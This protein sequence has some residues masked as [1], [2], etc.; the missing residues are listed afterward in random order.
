MRKET[1]T[2]IGGIV[3]GLIVG[4][5]VGG[6]TMSA[7]LGTAFINYNLSKPIITISQHK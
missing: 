3:I 4:A 6:F 7:I 5:L 1:K 2:F